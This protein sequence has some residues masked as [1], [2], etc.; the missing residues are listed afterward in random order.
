MIPTVQL[1]F[2]A[3]ARRAR[4]LAILAPLLGALAILTFATLSM[5]DADQV[6]ELADSFLPFYGHRRLHH[7]HGNLKFYLACTRLLSDCDKDYD[8]SLTIEEYKEFTNKVA[9]KKYKKQIHNTMPKELRELFAKYSGL[10]EGK[11]NQIIDIYGSR[12]GERDGISGK[13]ES[14]LEELC[15]STNVEI[16]NLFADQA[17]AEGE[18]VTELEE[19]LEEIIDEEEGQRYLLGIIPRPRRRRTAGCPSAA[20]VAEKKVVKQP[21]GPVHGPQSVAVNASM[22]LTVPDDMT[23]ADL[24]KTLETGED[25]GGLQHAVGQFAQEVVSHLGHGHHAP[26]AV[27]SSHGGGG[28]STNSSD[29]FDEGN[30]ID[31]SQDEAVVSNETR[32]LRGDEFELL[33]GT[34][35]S[36]DGG[37][38]DEDGNQRRRRLNI[39]FANNSAQ[40][41]AYVESICPGAQEEHKSALVS[42]MESVGNLLNGTNTT[43]GPTCVTA[44]FKYK[45]I[46]DEEE[47]EL[48]GG[49]ANIYQMAEEA[50]LAAIDDGTLEH[51]IEQEPGGGSGFHVEGK[52]AVS[53]DS[54]DPYEDVESDDDEDKGLRTVDIILISVGSV[55]IFCLCCVLCFV[56][57][58]RKTRPRPGVNN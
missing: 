34:L 40:I 29:S 55:L 22:S 57:L 19:C 9:D 33:P 51:I 45:I 24:Q 20:E 2:E 38:Y 23:V 36:Y 4:Y 28:N 30:S 37:F 49:L 7:P 41:Y 5:N 26:K 3:G 17:A 31:D 8:N 52:G 12:N 25:V 16:D 18:N 1:R 11:S 10:T 27:G 39:G 32:Y 44:L 48:D 15:N 13:Q 21:K 58:E 46:V 42:A 56:E 6:Q 35:I 53:D 54:F 50:T 47:E 14:Y 43:Q